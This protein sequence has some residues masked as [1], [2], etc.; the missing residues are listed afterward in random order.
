MAPDKDNLQSTYG[1]L[2]PE[3]DERIIGKSAE[4]V[5]RISRRHK[6]VSKFDP[7]EMIFECWSWNCGEQFFY[8]PAAW[9]QATRDEILKH[10]LAADWFID[11]DGD[12]FCAVCAQER[13]EHEESE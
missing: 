3:G 1:A 2:P 10:L 4:H 6:A 12:T 9:Q 7:P 5:E 8:K 11:A 13:F